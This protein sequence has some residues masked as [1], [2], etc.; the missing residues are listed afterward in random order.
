MEQAKCRLIKKKNNSIEVGGII[1]DKLGELGNWIYKIHR[2]WKCRISR[3]IVTVSRI[4][5]SRRLQNKIKNE[6]EMDCQQI[7][8]LI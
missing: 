4:K 7:L 5:N 6:I 2:L 3:S 1:K 8:N